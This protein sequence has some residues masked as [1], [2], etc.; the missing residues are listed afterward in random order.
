MEDDHEKTQSARQVEPAATSRVH[1][2]VHETARET[3]RP[4]GGV[5]VPIRSAS[6]KQTGNHGVG[7]RSESGACRRV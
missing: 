1:N 3:P 6:R 7:R 4:S 5:R 2:P